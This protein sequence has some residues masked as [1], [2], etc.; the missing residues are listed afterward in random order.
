VVNA[1]VSEQLN[2]GVG[3]AFKKQTNKLKNVALLAKARK[4]IFAYIKKIKTLL[5]L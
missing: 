2:T 1:E 5:N 3:C 4:F